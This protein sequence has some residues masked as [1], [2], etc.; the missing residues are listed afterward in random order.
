MTQITEILAENEARSE[1]IN[2]NV[3]QKEYKTPELTHYG[4]I[5]SLVQGVPGGGADAPPPF[6]AL[7]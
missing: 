7:S 6:A 1:E 2:S 3:T 5:S 4:G